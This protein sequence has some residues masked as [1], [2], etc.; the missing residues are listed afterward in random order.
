MIDGF[1][2]VRAAENVQ[3]LIS[4]GFNAGNSRLGRTCECGPNALCSTNS[5]RYPIVCESPRVIT[6][7]RVVQLAGV[8]NAVFLIGD[9][10]KYRQNRNFII[11]IPSDSINITSG[12]F[13]AYLLIKQGNMNTFGFSTAN[14][15]AVIRQN[16]HMFTRD[17]L[18]RADLSFFPE[19]APQDLSVAGFDGHDEC[20]DDCKPKRH[21]EFRVVSNTTLNDA[22]VTIEI[23]VFEC[24]QLIDREIWILVGLRCEN[25]NTAFGANLF[26]W[27]SSP[28]S[29]GDLVRIPGRSTNNGVFVVANF[30]RCGC[31]DG[32]IP[33]HPWRNW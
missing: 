20:K 3:R 16:S 8:D 5:H 2:P 29:C 21:F 13:P 12:N 26:A 32:N 17:G 1:F 4:C 10:D 27:V 19:L 33:V 14:I 24:E 25:V 11:E 22:S 23:L 15:E 30:P 9:A 7:E 28:R 18:L 6:I 31:H